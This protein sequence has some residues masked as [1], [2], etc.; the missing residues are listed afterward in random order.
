[1][2]MIRLVM[3]MFSWMFVSVSP[4]FYK[5]FTIGLKPLICIAM[6]DNVLD[7]SGNHLNYGD[8]FSYSRTPKEA[9]TE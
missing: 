4:C 1:M 8:S 6:P 3:L 2:K 9:E 5:V 7:V